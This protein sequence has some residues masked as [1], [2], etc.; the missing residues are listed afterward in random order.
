M[1]SAGYTRCYL[2]TLETMKAAQRLYRD[3]GF[4]PRCSPLGRT[5]HFACDAYYERA[6]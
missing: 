2:E 5:G 4:A 3:F 6:L 1:K